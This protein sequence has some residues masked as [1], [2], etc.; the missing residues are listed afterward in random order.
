MY[1]CV[2]KIGCWQSKCLFCVS[3][4]LKKIV[5]RF[6]L[7]STLLSLCAFGCFMNIGSWLSTA[8]EL[9]KAD[10]I[11]SLEG[12]VARI[13][14]GALLFHEGLAE[15]VL[16]T[17]DASYRQMLAQKISPEQILKADWSAQ[18]TYQEGLQIKALLAG[19][20][21]TSALI[22]TDPFHL[23]RIKWT[24]RHI[25]PDGSIKFSYISSDAKEYQGFW[26][27]NPNSRLFV[28]SELPKIVYYWVW[29]GLLGIAEDPEW[30]VE[31]ERGYIAFVR[32]VFVRRMV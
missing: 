2:V 4:M 25:I 16:V 21:Y 27:S 11:V 1:C 30:A 10:V 3:D 14:K 6:F 19:A 31:L 7:I 24:L 15:R 32:E 17:T 18:S 23:Y 28:L 22:V 13:I 29:H 9:K 26:W 12:G 5:V 8:D 20:K